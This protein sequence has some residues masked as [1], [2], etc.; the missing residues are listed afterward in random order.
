MVNKNSLYFIIIV[1]LIAIIIYLK[2][3]TNNTD[4]Q[5]QIDNLHKKNDSLTSNIEQRNIQLQKLDSIT[6]IY[7]L[8]IQQDKL[9][10]AKLQ[11]VADK[12]KRKYNEE[13]NRILSLTNSATVSEFTNTFK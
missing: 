7:K 8:E 5:T 9:E 3:N 6:N 10:L 13:H 11:Q 12:N 1:V 2:F 4:F